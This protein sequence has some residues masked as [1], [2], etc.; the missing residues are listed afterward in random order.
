MKI[1]IITVVLN[2]ISTIRSTIESVIGQTHPEI[3]YIIIDGGSTD[4]SKELIESYVNRIT[5]FISEPDDGMYDA[6]NKGIT[7][8]TGEIIGSLNA[9]DIY[10]SNRILETVAATFKKKHIDS[11]FADLHYVRESDLNKTVRYYSGKSFSPFRLRFGFM[12]PHP[13]FFVKKTIY[14]QFGYYKTNYHIAADFELIIRFLYTHKASYLYLP[15][16]MIRMTMGGKSTNSLHSKYILNREIVRG[17]RENGIYTN[18]PILVMKYF[19]KVFELFNF[20]EGKNVTRV[21]P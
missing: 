1:S 14:E 4:G 21:A 17:C 13:T 19:I 5:K 8:A 10:T 11:L 15:M 9:D 12:P 6:L 20:P 7:L 3:E 2:H 16:D 18:M